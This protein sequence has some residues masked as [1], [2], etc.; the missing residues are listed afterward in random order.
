ML[1]KTNL[2]S[3]TKSKYTVVCLFAIYIILFS[4]SGGC[5]NASPAENP[6]VNKQNIDSLLDKIYSYDASQQRD[7][8]AALGKMEEEGKNVIPK[9]LK[10]FKEA[11]DSHNEDKIR[12]TTKALA[13]VGAYNIEPIIVYANQVDLDK[14]ENI[15]FVLRVIGDNR[16]IPF[17][18][19]CLKADNVQVCLGA[20]YAISDMPDER[21]FEPILAILKE[22]YEDLRIRI[23][24]IDCVCAIHDSRA[25]QPLRNLYSQKPEGDLQSMLIG[26]LGVFHVREYTEEFIKLDK[27][28]T[29]DDYLHETI[30][31]ALGNLGDVMALDILSERLLDNLM[32]SSNRLRYA[33]ALNKIP[34]TRKSEAAYHV[35][36]DK[37]E[38]KGD[39]DIRLRKYCALIVADS[40]SQ[41][42]LEAAHWVLEH[43]YVPQKL[44]IVKILGKKLGWRKTEILKLLEFAAK[45]TDEYVRTMAKYEISKYDY[46]R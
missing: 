22:K 20:L 41:Y 6:S 31:D 1:Q 34:D 35:W 2:P 38:D 23:A 33:V 28:L 21:A 4:L 30:A 43:G 24:A 46:D 18:I 27:S 19:E 37:K 12:K 32:P 10:L 14:R 11:E 13:F 8:A 5:N 25:I 3:L 9:L 45:D 15:I 16:A 42:S 36:K 26:A 40:N 44:E 29:K 39:S 17:F 7:A